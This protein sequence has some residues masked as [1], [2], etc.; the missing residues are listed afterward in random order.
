MQTAVRADAQSLSRFP[1][2][3]FT[4]AEITAALAYLHDDL[5]ARFSR[6]Q[7]CS[8]AESMQLFTE[9]KKFLILCAATPY[10]CS[11]SAR[12]DDMWHVF[13]LHTEAYADFCQRFLGRFIHHRPTSAPVVAHRAEMLTDAKRLFADQSG[14]REDVWPKLK[15][16]AGSEQLV[17]DA[18]ADCDSSCSGDAYCS[19]N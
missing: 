8:V 4:P 18:V 6:D 5:V 12:L 11:P 2:K 19:E 7:A 9:V 1:L 17:P 16:V 13:V 15:R 14:I 3:V 10:P